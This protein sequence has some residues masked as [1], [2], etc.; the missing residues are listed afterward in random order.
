MPLR[1]SPKTSKVA[2]HL[3]LVSLTSL[4]KTRED[5]EQ[6]PLK[7]DSTQSG[8]KWYFNKSKTKKLPE[9]RAKVD[10]RGGNLSIYSSDFK[11][12]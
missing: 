1:N 8:I 9:K 11:L 6:G 12:D 10:F 4:K 3:N 2:Q 7:H 5:Q